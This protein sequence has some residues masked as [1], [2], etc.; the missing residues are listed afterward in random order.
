MIFTCSKCGQKYNL[1]PAQIPAGRA[2]AKCKKC[3]GPVPLTQSQEK[4]G[5][6][7]AK[8][9]Q[10]K[11]LEKKA[12]SA[13]KADKKEAKSAC[14]AYIGLALVLGIVGVALGYFGA[15]FMAAESDPLA[16]SAKCPEC[17]K[18]ET[19][20][21]VAPEP[22]EFDKARLDMSAE[23]IFNFAKLFLLNEASADNGIKMLKMA[24]EAP[25]AAAQY[26]LYAMYSKEKGVPGS[27]VITVRDEE[28]AFKWLKA[29]A[30]NDLPL[31]QISLST[32][33]SEGKFGEKDEAQAKAWLQKAVDGYKKSAEAGDVEAQFMLGLLLTGAG[34]NKGLLSEIL[35]ADKAAA[36]EWLGQAKK[37]G[38]DSAKAYQNLLKERYGPI[39]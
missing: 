22:S 18:C 21:A 32:A 35:P 17:P 29:A 37:Q 36:V 10:A 7:A 4:S 23:D 11:A 31:A 12:A 5:E 33:Y 3:G 25:S 38:I 24:A 6:T 30:E 1:D 13:K 15:Q 28:Q 20:A 8:M 34:A 14:G 9:Q 19:S 16:A 2:H 27:T 39:F 26:S